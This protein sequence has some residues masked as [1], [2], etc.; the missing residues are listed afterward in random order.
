MTEEI[1]DSKI[2]AYEIRL[3]KLLGE[4][5]LFEIPDY[6][7]PFVWETKNFEQLLDDIKQALSKMKKNIKILTIMN[8]TFLGVWLCKPKKKVSM[9]S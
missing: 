6:Q 4:G 5:Y 2:R 8:P 9:M 3:K 7:R 1:Q